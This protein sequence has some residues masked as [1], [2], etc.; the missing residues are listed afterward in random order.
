MDVPRYLE[1]LWTHRRLLL[2]GAVV[3]VLAGLLAGFTLQGGRVV[4]RAVHSY[5]ASTTVLVGSPSQPLYQAQV[6]GQTVTQGQ[7]APVQKDLTQAAV[8]YAYVVAGAQVRK[9]VEDQLG[10]LADDEQITALRRTTQPGGDETFP[11]RMSLPILDVV[12]VSSDPDRAEAIS[13][14][15]TDAFVNEVE[16]Q[17]DAVA[18]PKDERVE[19]SRLDAEPATEADASNPAIPV[20]VTA[21]GVLLVFVALAFILE[22]ARQ[23][24]GV[25]PERVRHLTR[26]PRARL[27]LRRRV[28]EVAEQPGERPGDAV[29]AEHVPAVTGER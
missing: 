2:A 26:R 16:G 13:A 5:S 27:P 17:Q 12:G 8:V 4:S 25:G 6:P 28:R 20:V 21:G 22:N 3:A 1:V 10:P 7:T 11:G 29:G 24:R 9:T 14:A 15:A 19:L 23:R 18:M